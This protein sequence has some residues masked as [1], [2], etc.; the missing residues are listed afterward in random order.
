MGAAEELLVA[1][2]SVA[3][4]AECLVQGQPL[5][6]A[7][8]ERRRLSKAHTLPVEIPADKVADPSFITVLQECRRF[9]LAKQEH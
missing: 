9:P 4:L 6:E 5:P 3:L 7:G 1:A 8:S 2:I